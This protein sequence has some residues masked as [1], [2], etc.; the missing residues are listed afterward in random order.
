MQTLN[1]NE[2]YDTNLSIFCLKNATV[3]PSLPGLVLYDIRLK[4]ASITS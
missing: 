1:T 4:L 3:K 2:E